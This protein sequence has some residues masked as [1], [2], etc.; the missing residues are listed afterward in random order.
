MNPII[1]PYMS[2]TEPSL[3]SLAAFEATVR[4]GSMSAA[5]RALAT[6]QPA[7]SQR[8]HRLEQALG[9]ALLDRAGQ[10]ARPTVSGR[11]YHDEIAAALQ[12]IDDASRRLRS[13]ASARNREL[14]IAVHF[15]FAHL[16]LLPRLSRLE[17]AFPGTG[18]EILPV[19]HDDAG[20][21]TAADLGIRFG[22]FD[23]D[24]PNEWPLI[25][26]TVAPVCSPMFA[27]KHGLAG[28]LDADALA[29]IPLLHMDER[30]PRWLDWTRWCEHAGCTAPA[31]PPRFQYKNYPLLLNA[32]IEGR[33]LALGWEG[34]IDPA[35]AEGT[36][37]RLGPAV[38]RAERG[39]I[40]QAAH[41]D[42]AVIHAVVGWFMRALGRT[43]GGAGRNPAS[44]D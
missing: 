31:E 26:E 7:I 2:A 35:L 22:L 9:I 40:L 25:A 12:R 18:F 14:R 30:D 10:R 29:G 36:L 32:A 27:D 15:G 4:L 23:R 34:L 20:E 13:R 16:W 37:V 43:K 28:D 42:R 11:A 5:A 21:M 1:F 33:G 39:Y 3:K 6:T 41:A 24:S 19:D 17:A 8:I 44:P 38:H